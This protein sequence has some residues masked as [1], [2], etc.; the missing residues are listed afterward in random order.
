MTRTTSQPAASVRA[1]CCGGVA[2]VIALRRHDAWESPDQHGNDPPGL[3]HRQRGLRD[4]R[5][6]LGIG[7]DDLFGIALVF[8]QERAGDL[9]AV[10][11]PHRADDFRMVAVPDH[12]HGPATPR[13]RGDFQVHLGHER[14]RRIQEPQAARPGLF[15]DRRR[16]A[17]RAEHDHRAWR[18]VAE[19]F[20]EDRAHAA[21]PFDDVVVVDDFVPDVHGRSE[22]VERT[23][24]DADGPVNPGAEAARVRQEDPHP[25]SVLRVGRSGGRGVIRGR[26]WLILPSALGGV[27]IRQRD[28]VSTFAP[29]FGLDASERCR[30]LYDGSVKPDNIAKLIAE[31]ESD[32]ELVG[33]ASLD[34]KSFFAIIQGA[35]KSQANFSSL[36][37][38]GAPRYRSS[39]SSESLTLRE[40]GNRWPPS[41]TARPLSA[42]GVPSNR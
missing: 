20:D 24:D 25:A 40:N 34:P 32:G 33:G 22:C 5:H 12:N 4:V 30:L 1:A 17:V 18:D 19:L 16:H 29:W 9:G 8:D 13:V 3:F 7:H 2:D 11:E 23:F 39:Q 35:A 31:P 27:K 38:F 21:Q 15:V 6:A 42:A 10:V 37:Q 26:R 36:D 41:Y 14:T 28:R